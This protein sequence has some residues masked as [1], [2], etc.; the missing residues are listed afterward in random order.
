MLIGVTGYAQ[1]GKDSIGQRLVEKHGFVRFAFA[2]QLKSMALVLDPWI[3][4]DVASPM[5]LST[6]VA[7]QGGW[8][9]AK[10]HGEVR[11]FLQVLGTEAVRDHLG[12]DSWV[13]ALDL[14]IEQAGDPI[15]VVITDVRFPNEARYIQENEGMMVRINRLDENGEVFDNGLAKDHPSEAFI[16]SLPVDFDIVARTGELETVV[17]PLIDSLMDHL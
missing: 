12:E 15:D 3:T 14:A 2:D 9:G 13:N 8:E 17:Y 5:R 11:R 10:A 6:F 4:F 7:M 16:E 1:H